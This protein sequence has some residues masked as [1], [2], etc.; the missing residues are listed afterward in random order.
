MTNRPVA[1]LSCLSKKI[2]S[3]R[4]SR[5]SKQTIDAARRQASFVRVFSSLLYL[6]FLY[7]CELFG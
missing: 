5:R 4:D 6:N 7:I 2:T 3:L 1:S